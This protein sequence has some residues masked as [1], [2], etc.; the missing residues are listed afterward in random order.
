MTLSF[1]GQCGSAIHAEAEMGEASPKAYIVQ[2][3][4]LDDIGP[5]EFLPSI[6]LNI[7]HRLNWLQCIEGAEQR[8]G[9][10]E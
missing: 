5:L 3:G 7:K 2:M 9:Y 4:T 10:A 8:K 1:C 6:E